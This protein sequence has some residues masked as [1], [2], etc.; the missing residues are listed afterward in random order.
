MKS[1]QICEN[2]S[3]LLKLDTQI[4]ENEILQVLHD[5][6][7]EGSIVTE[8]VDG[9]DFHYLF[10]LYLAEDQ[11]AKKI[12]DLLENPMHVD[13][14]RIDAW[15]NKYSDRLSMP[16]SETQGAAVKEAVSHRVFILT[17]GPGVGKTTTANAIIKLLTAMGRSVALAA[18]T[19]R[20]AQRLSEV[21]GLQAKTVH[22]LLE[23]APQESGFSRDESNPL[24]AQVIVVDEASMLD[25]KLARSLINSVSIN[26]QIIFIG[27]VDQLPSVGP[28]NVLRDLIESEKVPF[29]RLIEI[30]RQAASSNIVQIAHQ[31]NRGENPE[32]PQDEQ[33]DCRLLEVENPLY[34]KDIIKDLVGDTLPNKGNYDPMK[35]VQVLTPMNRGDLGTAKL[36]EELQAL[37]NPLEESSEEELK[38]GNT[39]FRPKDKVIQV[40]NNYEINVFNGDI[41]YVEHAGVEGGKLIVNFSG[42]SVKYTKE[43]SYDLRL[44]YAITIHK[45]QGSEF[46]VVIIPMSMQHFIMLQRNLI[47]TA[48]TRAK[49]FA[50]FVG[51]SKALNHASQ[52]LTSLKRQTHLVQRIKGYL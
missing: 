10:D 44:A 16:L 9:E 51:S 6:N 48:L 52:T 3:K 34:L 26:S 12:A 23:W 7:R 13:E 15:L 37:L 19:G 49:K 30:F 42:R 2:L 8:T 17:G 39:S 28:G 11:A 46:P 50:V 47:Y 36:N 5:L 1:E 43:D 29:C 4:I 45:S 35:D 38:P 32:F 41:G 24:N 31:I 14:S 21:T 18:P 22:R 25:I 33:S 40:S 20:A 27:D